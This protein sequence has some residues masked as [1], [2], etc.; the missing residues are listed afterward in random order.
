MNERILHSPRIFSKC[1]PLRA[2]HWGHLGEPFKSSV[3]R[4]TWTLTSAVGVPGFSYLPPARK[5]TKQW[6]QPQQ[7]MVWRPVQQPLRATWDQ[8][9][10]SSELDRR[11]AVI[12]QLAGPERSRGGR[13]AQAGPWL[14]K[15]GV[16][17]ACRAA[18]GVHRDYG[19]RGWR[20]NVGRLKRM[21]DGW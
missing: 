2:V 14:V 20:S 1:T 3:C 21:V 15:T 7:A 5:V 12:F 4:D 11:S 18:G 19:A 6:P 13:W 9:V 17:S 10:P 16:E 8:L